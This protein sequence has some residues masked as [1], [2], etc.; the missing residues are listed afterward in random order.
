[1]LAADLSQGGDAHA[2]PRS[3]ARA[4]PISRGQGNARLAR[5]P[6]V[7]L[8]LADWATA[9]L[10]RGPLAHRYD[11]LL[12]ER[13]ACALERAKYEPLRIAEGMNNVVSDQVQLCH[14]YIRE[15]VASHAALPRGPGIR[16]PA[17]GDGVTICARWSLGTT[18]DPKNAIRTFASYRERLRGHEGSDGSILLCGAGSQLR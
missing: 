1:V 18:D 5:S 3:K 2:P 16:P 17:S 15:V 14:D 4:S 6:T 10:S 8:R 7:Q 11:D 12:W 13:Q 9:A